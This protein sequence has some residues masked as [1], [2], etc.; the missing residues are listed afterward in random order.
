MPR[1]AQ[2]AVG[3]PPFNRKTRSDFVAYQVA[4][5]PLNLVTQATYHV[6]HIVSFYRD[7]LGR[8]LNDIVELHLSS[9]WQHGRSESSGRATGPCD[10]A[11]SI[12]ILDDKRL[13]PV[14]AETKNRIRS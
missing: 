3:Y 1:F 4:L 9:E 2:T 11:T 12:S 5:R 10:Q 7:H 14:L 13:G 6:G 8:D